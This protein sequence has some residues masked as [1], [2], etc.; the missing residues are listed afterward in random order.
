VCVCVC[1]YGTGAWT[2]GLH[3][4]PLHQ[5]FFV[6]GFFWE[7]VSQNYLPWLAL[8]VILLISA[9]V[10]CSFVIYGL[11]YVDVH[12]VSTFIMK[13]CWILSKHFLHLLRWFSGFCLLLLTCCITFNYLHM[14]NHPCIPGM[15]PTWSWYW[16]FLIS[17]W[18]WFANILLRIFASIFIKDIGL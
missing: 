5:H 7:R 12:S 13:G 18:I 15:K 4:K 2:Q 17:C 14:L 10:V 6:K 3:L 11:Y 9:S 1:V 16:I 8:N